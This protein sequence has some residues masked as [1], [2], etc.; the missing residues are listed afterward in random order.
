MYKLIFRK[1]R[2]ILVLTMVLVSLYA[3]LLEEDIQLKQ[4]TQVSAEVS[5]GKTIVVD[6]GQRIPWWRSRK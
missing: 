6:V 2:I 3:F 4:V 5:E 1:K